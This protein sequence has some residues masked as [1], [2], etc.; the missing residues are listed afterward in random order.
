NSQQIQKFLRHKDHRRINTWLKDLTQK[1]YLIRDYNPVFGQL[2]KPAVYSLSINGRTVLKK[3]YP[4]ISK[5]HLQR[6]ADDR[7]RS[8]GFRIHCQILADIYLIL[9]PE[10]VND[11]IY[12][13]NN[14]LTQGIK[15]S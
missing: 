11:M 10:K 8:K 1:E 6:M 3:L 4:F 2:T 15:I 9:F 7:T 12:M 13:I 5:K 14:S